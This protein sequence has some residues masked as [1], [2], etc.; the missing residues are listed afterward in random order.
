MFKKSLAGL[1]SIATVA[2]SLVAIA[3][4]N[5][6][7]SP[8]GIQETLNAE[9]NAPKDNSAAAQ[10]AEAAA[11]AKYDKAIA[12]D[13]AAKKA[14][15]DSVTAEATAKK[16][17]NDSATAEGS[18]K[19]TYDKAVKSEVS[20]KSIY[21]KAVTSED[22]A[23]S[24]YDKAVTSEGSAKSIYDK[25]V[26]SEN[27]AKIKYEANKTPANLKAYQ[28]AQNTTKTNLTAYQ[29]AQNTTK[30]N[31]TAYQTAQN[32][33]K[34]NLT[35]Y[36]TAQNTTKTNLTAYQTAQN[37]TKTNL[38]SL[39]TAKGVKA[40]ELSSYQATQQRSKA[41]GNWT[42][43]HTVQ[44]R[45]TDT[46]GFQALI[47]QF[48]A[49]LQ[50]EGKEIPAEQIA[51]RRLDPSKLFLKQDHEVKAWFVGEGAGYR[52]Q[53][54]YESLRGREYNKG[55]IFSDASCTF[56]CQMSNGTDGVLDIGDYVTLGK[57]N[58]KTQFN[59]LLKADGASE[60]TQNGDIYGANAALNGDKLQHLMAWQVGDYVL[61]G[62]EDLRGGGDKDYNDLMFAVD[63]GKD[64]L[65]TSTVP[66][67]GTMTALLGITGAAGWLRR[68]KN[69]ASA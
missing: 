44:D 14:Y 41:W 64:N 68:R 47:P 56:G 32:T 37:T 38:S 26:T 33:T 12:N 55:M 69:Q 11:K 39:Q 52:N 1:F 13:T 61:M 35:A 58:T 15:D 46:S 36:Q 60:K 17:Y 18:T 21:D 63:F 5:A 27:S 42:T 23:K 24:I 16:T 2:G 29:T 62:F 54:A 8:K 31:L 28:T 50:K 30:T 51:A 48:Q 34:T 4:A 19:S 25:A 49:L 53:L 59:F 40:Y 22:T 7:Q 3:P 66:E 65:K 6:T 57:F 67:P 45:S 20:A 9:K 10:A 43:T